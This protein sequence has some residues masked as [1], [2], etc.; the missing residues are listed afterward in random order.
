MV[1]KYGLSS[2]KLTEALDQIDFDVEERKQAILGNYIANLQNV[3]SLH[4]REV[5]AMY[6]Y[7]DRYMAQQ[8]Q[9]AKT[10]AE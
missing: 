3:N 2:S 4:Q 6:D 5:Q 7:Q 10:Y 8:D 9:Y 1:E